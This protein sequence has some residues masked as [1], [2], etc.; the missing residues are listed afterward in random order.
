MKCGCW[1]RPRV[2]DRDPDTRDELV[3][4]QLL[5]L[6][7]AKRV[8]LQVLLTGE[9]CALSSAHLKETYILLM[10]IMGYA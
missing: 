9:N 7:L 2:D 8:S 4:S 3:W 10:E 6:L 1:G 5:W